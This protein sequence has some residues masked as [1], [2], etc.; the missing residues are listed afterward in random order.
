MSAS[1]QKLDTTKIARP[2]RLTKLSIFASG[3]FHAMFSGSDEYS[4]GVDI[5][6]SKSETG[7]QMTITVPDNGEYIV[8]VV[9]KGK[10]EDEECPPRI[11]FL[12]DACKIVDGMWVC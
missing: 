3:I 6:T 9:V 1:K 5:K 2:G 7:Y 8:A 11:V 12:A 4:S 10:Q